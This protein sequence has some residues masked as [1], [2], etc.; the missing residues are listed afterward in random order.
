[1]EDE[2]VAEVKARWLLLGVSL[3]CL[4]LLFPAAA[5]SQAARIDAGCGTA[6][7]DGRVGAAEWA[8][9]AE[10]PLLRYDV[11][12]PA[13][14]RPQIEGVSPSQ[15]ETGTAYFMNDDRYLYVGAELLD[16]GDD[17]PNNPHYYD[18]FMVFA[19]EDEP[20][21]DPAAWVD[22]TWEGTS[23]DDPADEG[24]LYGDDAF[25]PNT[26]YGG[27]YFNHWVAPH[28]NCWDAAAANGVAFDWAPRGG[29]ANFE[30]RVDLQNSPVDN[31][32]PG[33]GDCF[34]LRWMLTYFHGQTVTGLG[35]SITGGWPYE[36]VDDADYTG[37]CSVLC[38]N[39]CEV[40]EEFVPEPGTLMLLG[41]GLMGL[42]GYATLR[43]RTRE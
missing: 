7:I 8:N 10:L 13:E 20:A 21:G 18:V 16:A 4:L 22:C 28:E 9:A 39:P 12:S 26:S 1:M 3:I 30:M 11:G 17:I 43:W 40:E 32:D 14:G 33:D 34:G 35:S 31:P 29:G 24:W 42:S 41:S 37:D 25:M 19:F 6:I 15:T 36:P 27:V 38:L 2:E 5:L 23:C